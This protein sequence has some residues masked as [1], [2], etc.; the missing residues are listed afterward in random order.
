MNEQSGQ[1]VTVFGGSGFVGRH[2]VRELAKRGYRVR[3]A[4]RRPDLAGHLQPMGG[5]SQ[6]QAVQANLRYPDS[7]RRA[8]SGASAVVNLVG[9]LYQGG[10]QKFDAVQGIGAANIAQAAAQLG[11][12]RVVHVSAIGADA[13]SS[14]L[15]A[16]SKAM[17]EAAMFA[18]RPDAIILRPSLIF[19][20]EDNFFNKFAGLS[21]ILPFLPLIGGGTTRFQPVYVDDVALAIAKGVDGALKGGTVYEL[22]G[23]QVKTFRELMEIVLKNTGRATLLVPIPSFIAKIKAFFLQMLP[24][25]LLTVDQVKLLERDNVVSDD[26]I[27]QGRTLEGMG[28]VPCA[29]DAKVP[30]YLWRFRKG[31]EF[32]SL[33]R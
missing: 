16:R 12:D 21:T 33:P 14:S 8:M 10:A 17:G 26:A 7:V 28:I 1:I 24:N 11:I 20:A 2:V 30:G 6:I 18:A 3:V 13:D 25:P 29:I 5:V 22:G 9:I 23:P 19:G 4:V 31:G 27:A 15:Y 32:S